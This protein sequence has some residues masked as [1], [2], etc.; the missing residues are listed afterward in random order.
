VVDCHVVEFMPH[1]FPQGR[2]YGRI[3]GKDAFSVEKNIARG[4]RIY[5]EMKQKAL[6]DKPLDPEFFDHVSG[7]Q[8]QV[9]EIIDSI[10]TDAGRVY[11]AN[12][13]NTGQV[14]NLPLGAI[15]EAPAVA[16]AGGLRHLAQNPLPAGMAGTL[17]TRFMWVETVVEAALEGSRDKFVQALIL[18]GAVD[19]LETAYNLA[20]ELLEFHK[21]YL[22]QFYP[23]ERLKPAGINKEITTV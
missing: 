11:S 3:L 17:A 13:P 15:I 4:D 6:D 19:S 12:L 14:P 2:Y 1:L 10:R 20:D 5:E 23:I 22:P 7:E 16:D 18:D 21:P 9:I 8:E